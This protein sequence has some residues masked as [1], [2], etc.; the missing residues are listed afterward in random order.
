MTKE[1][2]E[3]WQDTNK[4]SQYTMIRRDENGKLKAIFIMNIL[5]NNYKS[6]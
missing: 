6:C 1:E 3:Q 2:F 4:T 5:K